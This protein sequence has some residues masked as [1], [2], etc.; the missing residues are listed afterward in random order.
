MHLGTGTRKY[1]SPLFYLILFSTIARVLLAYTIELS[2][3][4]AY[5]RILA[6]NPQLGYAD[7]PPLLPYIINL[8]T[9]NYTE[10]SEI[11]T[12]L[13]SI[14]IGSVN[15]VLIYLI[16]RKPIF[17]T[18][19]ES[20]SSS[21][22]STA[23][24]RRGFIAS[25]LYTASIYAG[26]VIGT[27]ATSDALMSLFW[28]I[29]INLLSS[30]LPS[31]ARYSHTKML[32]AGLFVGLA[33][34][35]K[36]TGGYLWVA[37]LLFSLL[38]NRK[39]LKTWSLYFAIIISA[40]VIAP[41]I[42]WN[43]NNNYVGFSVLSEK[44]FSFN[45]LSS[46]SILGESLGALI[47]NGAFNCLIIIG[48]LL[49]Y[50]VGRIRFMTKQAMRFT[51]VFSLPLILTVLVMSF[52]HPTMPHWSAPAYFTLIIVGAAHLSNQSRKSMKFWQI[53][54]ISSTI[55]L[56]S[57]YVIQVQFGLF[58][59][60]SKDKSIYEYGKNMPSLEM[61]GWEQLNEKF[62]A[63]Y[64][65]DL[66]E[67]IMAESPI[68]ISSK[69]HEAAHIDNYVAIP[70]DLDLITLCDS[71]STYFY[72]NIS[73]KRLAGRDIETLQ[74]YYIVSSRLFNDEA[75]R[76]L[77]AL[78]IAQSAVYEAIPIT[79]GGDIVEIFYVYRLNPLSET[80]VIGTMSSG[81]ENSGGIYLYSFN[82]TDATTSLKSAT[83]A[84]N[85]TFMTFDSDG[86][87]LWAVEETKEETAAV[88]SFNFD[89]STGS[90]SKTS[91]ELTGGAL[92]CH[93]LKGDNWVATAN[94]G[95][96]SVSTF[97][98][99]DN[100]T[101]S[102]RAQLFDF[103]TTKKEKASH[104]HCLIPTPDESGIIFATDLGKDSIYRF[105]A[106]SSE[107]IKK[108]ADIFK[109]VYPSIGVKK[110]SG[111]RH[112]TFAP[113]GNR[114]YLLC[115]LSGDVIC[116]DYKDG[117]LIEFQTAKS[118][119]VGGRGCADIH[120]SSDGRFLYTSNRHKADGIST[121][122]IDEENGTIEKIDYTLT[123]KHPRNFTLTADE[124]YLLVALRD[125]GSVQIYS[126]NRQSG[127]LTYLGEE[128]D[129]KI[130]SPMFVKFIN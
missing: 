92:P 28:L 44:L 37:T 32:T 31:D 122:A 62:T 50:F 85:P 41:I 54:S 52:F 76:V 67:G 80:I 81:A 90:F 99:N 21:M 70:N 3:D 115:E 4:E 110:G 2:N 61:Y 47:F 29:S 98:L 49:S 83:D 17:R 127:K 16:A 1:F 75:S 94:Y 13:V 9:L 35:S 106:S 74:G 117:N 77:S 10:T 23:D 68:L 118:D 38:F 63:L 42:L 45:E 72:Q 40:G 55:L 103:N 53:L 105:V 69:W 109:Q 125:S 84:S 30:I 18:V 60:E 120:I 130:K 65:N 89:E 8:L 20:Y 39:V 91:T 100:S 36:Y 111:P 124:R 26:I 11:L 57:M 24:Y 119:S 14:F 19:Q 15:T 129:I 56:V 82:P 27:F 5:Y 48:A 128:F 96:G 73:A 66:A 126:R 59:S 104:L 87:K 6:L 33:M 123:G 86:N 79:R 58:Y 107:D 7:H 88:A 71:D 114:A 101:V 34:L 112:L 25:V 116:F 113:N 78:G 121:F 43:F 64:T 108:G 95:S 102:P 51:M 46:S 22:L 12:R 93:I 97:R